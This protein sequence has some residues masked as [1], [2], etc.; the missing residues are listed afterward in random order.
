M[1]LL[2]LVS[3]VAGCLFIAFFC[4]I[5]EAALF[6]V[7]VGVVRH[8]AEE[9]QSGGA[10]ALVKLKDDIA[11]PISALLILNTLANTAG[12]AIAGALAEN[13]FGKNGLIIFTL[14]VSLLVLFLGEALPKYLGVTYNKRVA[15][16]V[17]PALV[18]LVTILSPVI[19]LLGMMTA[20]F[21]PENDAPSVSHEEVLSMAAIG[22][23]EGTIDVLEGAV[24]SNVIGLDKVRVGELVTPRISVFKV[25]ENVTIASQ[26][27]LINTWEFTRIP[28]YAE[29]EPDNLTG[30]VRQRDVLRALING[31]DAA[32]LSSLARPL[33]TVPELMRADKLLVRMFEQGE[34]LY[35]VVDE[36]GTLAGIISMEDI[37]EHVVGRD[38]HD[39][40]DK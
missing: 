35:S 2:V 31:D 9:E 3:L 5:S 24:I 36:H 16:T 10:I 32:P 28:V 15:L 33:V 19:K 27:E 22:H 18:G 30:Y 40:Y 6:A 1:D 12:P 29:D 4:S 7:P 21:E 17:A 23:Q 11:G 37:L 39:E 20:R 34:H 38:I 25:P 26:R 8:E 13:L 14:L